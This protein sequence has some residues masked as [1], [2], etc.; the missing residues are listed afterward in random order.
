[1]C[2]KLSLP[3]LLPE[4]APNSVF[5]ILEL[6]AQPHCIGC[7]IHR[8]ESRGSLWDSAGNHIKRVRFIMLITI[9]LHIFRIIDLHL[10]ILFLIIFLSN[11]FVNELILINMTGCC[12]VILPANVS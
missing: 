2:S 6:L 7:Q 4:C 1:M 11:F 12:I 10:F 9:K 5:Y 3:Q 8:A